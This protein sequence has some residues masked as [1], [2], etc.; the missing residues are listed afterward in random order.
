MAARLEKALPLRRAN[1][2]RS[3]HVNSGL[4]SKETVMREWQSLSYE[5]GYCCFNMEIIGIA[6]AVHAVSWE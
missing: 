4:G 1:M 6:Q 5:I 2:R 3:P